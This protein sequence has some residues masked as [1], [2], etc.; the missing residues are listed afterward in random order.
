VAEVD[1]AVAFFI[2]LP[3]DLFGTRASSERQRVAA[4]KSAT[5]FLD[6]KALHGVCGGS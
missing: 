6:P 1:E 5:A 4:I 2:A 3:N